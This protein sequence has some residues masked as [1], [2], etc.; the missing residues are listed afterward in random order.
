V[1]ELG[2]DGALEA[3][4]HRCRFRY[5]FVAGR[6]T[7]SSSKRVTLQRKTNK[8]PGRYERRHEIRLERWDGGLELVRFTTPGPDE[9][10][11]L[12]RGDEALV[13]STMRGGE[14]EEVVELVD[15][16]TRE[17]FA[18]QDPGGTAAQRADQ[19]AG[20]VWVVVWLL[21]WWLT[22]LGVWSSLLLGLGAAVVVM[23][24][25]RTVMAPRVALDAPA[26]AEIAEQQGLLQRK[27]GL[28]DKLARLDGEAAERERLRARLT[29]LREKMAAVGRELYGA[30]MDTVDRA[31]KLLARQQALDDRLRAEYRRAITVLEIEHETARATDALA[32]DVLTTTLAKLDELRA[33]EAENAALRDELQANDEVTRLSV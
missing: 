13:V 2:P 33:V 25:G 27:R 15:V 12:P 20:T 14:V 24:A 18:L 6:V 7:R 16:T 31:L 1:G 32:S 19:A 26:R 30:R 29:G 5:R 11:D 4:C 17:R 10:V 9:V 21:A 22:G 28:E 8:Q 23:V 3:V